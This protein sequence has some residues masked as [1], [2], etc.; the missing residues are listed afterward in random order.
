MREIVLDTETTGLRPDKG[1]KIVEIGC[2]E[3]INKV[4][5][6]AVFHKYINPGRDIP[7]EARAVHGLSEGF[8]SDKPK[9]S[10]IADELLEFLGGS[11]LIIHN[12]EFD[13][14]F[15]NA[16]LELVNRQRISINRTT[17][18]I[19]LAR[20]KF[21][22]SPAS[23]DALCKRF[24]IDCSNRKLHGALLDSQLLA[25]VY[26]ELIGGRQG[27]FKLETAQYSADHTGT[28]EKKIRRPR[29][30]PPNADELAAHSAF[31]GRLKNS[32]WNQ[33]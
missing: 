4:S 1:D 24:K 12:A 6:G 17:D 18:T 13:I 19:R 26:Q 16:E 33:A 29:K 25:E 23:L 2:V 11:H 9:F 3:L 21:P 27:G 20:Q 8:L 5:S 15:L 28:P 30:A 10:E 14:S 22:G 32:L 31:I 7:E